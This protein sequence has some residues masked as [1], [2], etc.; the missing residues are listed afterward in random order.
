[1]VSDDHKSQDT[2][3]QPVQPV[4]NIVV[5]PPPSPLPPKSEIR[6]PVPPPPPLT[7]NA[8]RSRG[9]PSVLEQKFA[10][11]A[12]ANYKPEEAEPPF[13]PCFF[14]FYGSLMDPEVLQ[15][16]L[17]LLEVPVVEEGWV[18]GF[19]MKM[20]GIYPALIP[21]KG[22]K[23][24]GMVWKVNAQSHFLRFMEYETS[25]Y[26]WCSCDIE[27]SNGETL[28]DCRTFYWAGDPDSKELEEGKFDL[29]R[30]QKYFKPS[31]VR[32]GPSKE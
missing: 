7:P 14:F 4:S 5:P 26:T 19:A 3:Q 20:W 23:V 2:G 6:P 8:F 10:A 30:Y 21:R 31:V 1:M 18:T 15:A 9:S 27:L 11:A 25:A 16:V 12:N 29:Q 17:G 32:K 28:R 13:K 24:F 22:G